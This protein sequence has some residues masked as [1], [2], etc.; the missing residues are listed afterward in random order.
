[1]TA[2]ADVATVQAPPV[3]ET[4]PAGPAPFSASDLHAL[5]TAGPKFEAG[6]QGARVWFWAPPPQRDWVRQVHQAADDLERPLHE[7]A[8]A[9]LAGAEAAE[10]RRRSQALATALGN[11]TYFGQNAREARGQVQRALAEGADPAGPEAALRHAEQE[12]ERWEGRA[13]ALQPLVAEAKAR[14]AAVLHGC[15]NDAHRQV[16][17]RAAAEVAE[18][19]RALAEAFAELLAPLLAAQFQ[20]ER[21]SH[22]G[23]ADRLAELPEEKTG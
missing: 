20:L 8:A 23:T 13:A 11:A 3:A 7:A 5:K 19:R 9:A 22:R 17:A 15:V 2:T 10:L 18:R 14:A 12:R 6:P 1:M 16:V 4:A 21:V